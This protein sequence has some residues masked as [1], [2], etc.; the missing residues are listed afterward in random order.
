MDMDVEQLEAVVE[1]V[2]EVL[3]DDVVGAYLFG[4]MASGGLRPHSDIDVLAVT[5]R[6]STEDEKRR[7]IG[8]LL[9]ISKRPRPIE[10]TIVVD[11]EVKPWRYPPKMDLQYGDWW[12][13]EFERGETEPWGSPVNPDLASLIRMTLA[14]D[15]PLIGPPPSDVFDPIPRKDYVAALVDG[16]DGLM[17]DLDGDETNVLLTLARIWSG[18]ETDDLRSKDAAAHHVGARLPDEHRTMLTRARDV[19]LGR[20][21]NDWS[22][23]AA[24]ARSCAAYMTDRIHAAA[25][26]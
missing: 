23:L 26:R 24:E 20:Q 19:Y 5:R 3:G 21:E 11:H 4:S 2:R 7:L 8:S 10:F 6:P 25:R 9:K 13:D 1:L 18:I 22:G 14:A 17:A 16:I 15:R 12:R